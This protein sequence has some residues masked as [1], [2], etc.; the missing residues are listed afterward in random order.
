ME[1]LLKVYGELLP[2]MAFVPAGWWIGK[3]WDVKS[4]YVS[5]P[6]IKV[7]LPL[8][9][10][11]NMLDADP[12]KLATLPV[13]TFLLALLMNYVAK[14]FHKKVPSEINP[15]LLRSAFS[16]FNIAFFGIPIVTALFGKEGVSVLICIYLGSALY[17]DTIGFY[18]VA[19]TKQSAREALKE[20]FKIPFLYV[21]I[22][23]IIGKIAGL[24]TPESLKPVADVVSFVVS[25][26]GMLIVGLQ[27]GKVNFKHIQVKY[28][29]KLLAV[30]TIAAAV[31][32]TVITLL[33]SVILQDLDDQDYRMLAFVPL[34]PVAANVTVFAAFLDA[35]EEP[36]ALL[37]FL[38]MLLS[39]VLVSI[40]TPLLG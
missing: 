35:D 16:F 3:K 5:W 1:K 10:F 15:L 9:V 37:V 8:L 2:V 24:E 23:G 31:I 18:Q 40:A 21:F 13:V 29:S 25:A 12:S 32:L 34:F 20:V 26:M 17:G 22:A 28:F 36:S 4:S 6:L 30:R 39:V 11:G 27:L 19:R 33:A 7:L 14:F 38:S